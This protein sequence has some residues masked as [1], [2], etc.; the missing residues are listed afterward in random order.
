MNEVCSRGGKGG[1]CAWSGRALPGATAQHVLAFLPALGFDDWINQAFGHSIAF[2]VHGAS[3]NHGILSEGLPAWV[4]STGPTA[5]KFTWRTFLRIDAADSLKA[6]LRGILR[7]AH[8]QGRAGGRAGSQVARQAAC[9]RMQ[10]QDERG[11]TECAMRRIE[12]VQTCLQTRR[13]GARPAGRAGGG[14]RAQCM[15]RRVGN[16]PRLAG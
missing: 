13:G 5:A 16:R 9:A 7:P 11:S 6:G 15:Q 2:S 10:P 12:L 3:R 8:K 1:R 14:R 4:N